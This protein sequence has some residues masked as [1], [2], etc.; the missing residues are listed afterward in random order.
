MSAAALETR[1]QTPALPAVALALATHGL[2]FML[3]YFGIRWQSAPPAVVEA[4]LWRELPRA[5]TLAARPT[6]AAEP[7]PPV[8][9]KVPAPVEPAPAPPPKPDIALREERPKPPPKAKPVVPEKRPVAETAKE[10]R[11]ADDPIARELERERIRSQLQS[12]TRENAEQKAAAESAARSA[13]MSAEW[14]DRVRLSVRGR[15]PAPVAA[16]VQGN[17]EA[18][19][20]VT[21]LVGREVDQVRRVRSSGNAAYD[22]AAERAIRAASPFPAPPEGVAQ[23]RSLTLRMRPKDE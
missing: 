1:R 12:A 11:A 9:V 14:A 8:A 10:T 7:A 22:E 18:V 23:Q 19:F 6:P 20:E 16:A 5:E 3:L 13:R 2:L 21:L 17:P 15:I 4:E